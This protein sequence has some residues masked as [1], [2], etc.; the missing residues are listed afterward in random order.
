VDL[1]EKLR[2]SLVWSFLIDYLN[3][4]ILPI[5][6]SGF[7][8]FWMWSFKNFGD[9]FDKIC[10]SIALLTVCFAAPIFKLVFLQRK[11][12]ELQTHDIREKF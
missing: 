4:A 2:K 10:A 5:A 6:L 1:R 12:S 11:R 8:A 3:Q 9:A 7:I